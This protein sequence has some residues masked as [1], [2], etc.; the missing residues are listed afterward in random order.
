MFLCTSWV[1]LHWHKYVT[2]YPSLH[3]SVL[4]NRYSSLMN[5]KPS[6]CRITVVGSVC[7]SVCLSVKSHLTSGASVCPEN[8]VTYLAGNE[9][10]KICGVFSE[11]A[12]LWRSST[13]CIV[14]LCAVGHFYSQIMR[15]RIIRPRLACACVYRSVLQYTG[16]SDTGCVQGKLDIQG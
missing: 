6:A 16:Y 9:G 12:P 3:V 10:P 8:A 13:S 7:L 5:I 14:R 1:I 2:N 11:T 4:T 15:M